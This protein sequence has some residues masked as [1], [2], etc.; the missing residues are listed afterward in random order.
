MSRLLFIYMAMFMPLYRFFFS[1]KKPYICRFAESHQINVSNIFTYLFYV[2]TNFT[3]LKIQ[4]RTDNSESIGI[5][6]FLRFFLLNLH[7]FH[8][9]DSLVQSR[10]ANSCLE[11]ASFLCTEPLSGP[12]RSCPF[13]LI[14]AHFEM[15]K[16][17]TRKRNLSP[18]NSLGRCSGLIRMLSFKVTMRST[19]FSFP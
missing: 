16:L 17:L 4:I 11:P 15:A 9:P 8:F 18:V 13:P 1:L 2:Y 7:P 3:L 14:Q 12:A 6:P 5:I 19:T 10:S